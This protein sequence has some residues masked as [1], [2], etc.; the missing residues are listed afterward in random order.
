[1]KDDSG[2]SAI[3]LWDG[4][5]DEVAEKVRGIN[6]S[7]KLKRKTIGKANGTSSGALHNETAYG[8]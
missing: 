4:F 1:M 5:R 7:H 3:D 6:V 8:L 2:H